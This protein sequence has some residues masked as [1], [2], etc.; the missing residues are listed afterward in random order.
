MYVFH[1]TYAPT[2]ATCALTLPYRVNYI[3]TDL[4]TNI[5]SDDYQLPTPPYIQSHELHKHTYT[6]N[7]VNMARSKLR[8]PRKPRTAFFVRAFRVFD[9]TRKRGNRGKL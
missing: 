5:L 6:H 4:S 7:L 8:K 1:V 3:V 2:Q 9:L